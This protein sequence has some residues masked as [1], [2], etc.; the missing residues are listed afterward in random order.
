MPPGAA[1]DAAAEEGR[2]DRELAEL[3]QELRVLLPGTAVLFGFLL[4]LSFS[5][6]LGEVTGAERGL[7]LGAFLTTALCTVLLAAPGVRHRT[8][9]RERDK[10]ALLASANRIALAASALLALALAAVTTLVVEH[11]YGWTAGI[12]AGLGL[13]LLE[14]WFWFGWAFLRRVHTNR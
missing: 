10:E 3:L 1:D 11:L 9:F 4:A 5:A 12:A 6:Q 8:R 13:L 2:L 7:F 14:S